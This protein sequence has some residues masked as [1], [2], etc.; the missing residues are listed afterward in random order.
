MRDT[1][2]GSR[3]LTTTRGASSLVPVEWS[4]YRAALFDLDG[5]ITPTAR[6]H[7]RAW[8]QMF[9][10]FLAAHGEEPFTRQDYLDHVDGK[11]RMAGVRD[12]LASRDITLPE[13]S[14][15]R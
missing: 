7:V 8:T 6:I 12:V 2:D 1:R 13:R 3:D 11:P 15:E 10:E 9:D 4:R 5:V 14:E